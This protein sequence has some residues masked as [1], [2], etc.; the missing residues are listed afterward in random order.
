VEL[1]EGRRFPICQPGPLA[2]LL[3]GAGLDQVETRPIDVPTRFRDF[4]D[5]WQPF[6]GGQGPA[7]GYN[8]SLSEERRTALRERLRAALPTALDG[9]IPLVARAWAVRGTRP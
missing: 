2:A 7:A 6:L 8:M 5:Y 1:D 3:R 9:S 4:D